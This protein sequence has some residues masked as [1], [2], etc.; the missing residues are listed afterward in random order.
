M[1]EY[2]PTLGLVRGVFHLGAIDAAGGEDSLD[3]DKALA[4][5]DRAI[6]AHDEQVRAAERERCAQIVDDYS[7]SI[8]NV[9]W[10]LVRNIAAAIRATP[11]EQK[12]SN[13]K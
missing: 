12:E 13:Q 8:E 4:M 10:A 1:S 3:H 7:P 6:A 11:A 2:T 9:G 5:F